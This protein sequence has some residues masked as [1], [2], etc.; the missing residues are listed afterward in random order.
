MNNYKHHADISQARERLAYALGNRIEIVSILKNF[1]SSDSV[2]LLW[3]DDI[4]KCFIDKNSKTK[5]PIKFLESDTLSM[6]GEAY[7]KKA[8][9]RSSHI[10]YDAHYNVAI[11]NPFKLDIS[12]QL[13]LPIFCQQNIVGIIRFSKNKHTF[14]EVVL[15]KLHHLESSLVDIFSTETDDRVARLNESFFSVDADQVYSRLDNIKRE[16]K[17]LS[18]DTHNPEVKK[19]IEKAEESISHICDYIRFSADTMP[20]A[21]SASS[22]LHI[23]IADDVH[24]NVK[25]L[26]AMLK[27]ESDMDIS[28]AYDGVE[29]LEKIEIAKQNENPVN[30]LYL[31]HY[32]PGKLGLEVAQEIREEEKLNPNH[33]ITIVSITNDPSAIEEQKSLY[34]YHISKP[35]SKADINSVME[36]IT[37]IKP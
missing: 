27:G 26:H 8:P 9:Y 2:D 13:I 37:T 11:D 25:I 5:I 12:A 23:L 20:T 29:T 36:S 4:E 32:M 35:F 28:L 1:T 31:D 33:K 22:K 7:K 6:I 30:V 17:Q 3:Y 15:Q 14:H 34:D 24:M 10:R 21:K 18:H 16:I 19:I